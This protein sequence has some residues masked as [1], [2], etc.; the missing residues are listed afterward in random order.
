MSAAKSVLIVGGGMSGMTLGTGLKRAGIDCEIV[1]IRPEWAEP[2]TG[3]SLQGPALRALRTVGLLDRCIERGFGY[4][5]F[6]AC[7]ANGNVT[8]TV[9]LPSLLGPGYPATIGIM[10]YAVHS[11][12]AEELAAQKVPVRLGLSVETLTQDDNGVDVTFTDGAPGRYDLV[13]G[14]DGANSRVRELLFGP[15]HQPYYTGQ[16]NWRAT[17]SRPP[18]VLC[19]HSYFGPTN[20]SGFN[21]ISQTEMYVYILQNIPEKPRWEPEEW[22]GIIRGLLA[23]F[24]GALGRARDEI[25]DP[26]QLICRPV[27]SLMMPP[28]WY[29]GRVIIIGDAAHTTTPQ[30]ASGASIAIEDSILLTMLLQSD[31]PIAAVLENFMRRRYERCRMI[32][33]NSEQLGEWEK[34]PNAPDIDVVGTVDRSYK[35]LAQPI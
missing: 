8:G 1:E 32:V 27:T 25:V 29:R 11:V 35:A 31:Q 2:S 9:E 16:V 22:P 26:D 33:K 20:K 15:K 17:V 24:G 13:V 34:N 6:K 14:T 18:D 23:E 21:P 7:D 19:R 30:L 12:L 3:I 28:P 4:S 10:R 5:Q